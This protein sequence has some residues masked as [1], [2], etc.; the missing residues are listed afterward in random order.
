MIIVLA[1]PLPASAETSEKPRLNYYRKTLCVKKTYNLNRSFKLKVIGT[2]SNVRFLTSNKKIAAVNTSG[3]VIAKK[4]GKVTITAT[5][6]G[7]KLKCHVTVKPLSK[8]SKLVRNNTIK[9]RYKIKKKRIL[10]IN[11]GQLSKYHNYL[12]MTDIGNYYY[13]TDNIFKLFLKDK[14]T[15][16]QKNKY[17]GIVEKYVRYK[18]SK[19]SVCKVNKKGKIIPKKAGSAIV[20]VRLI[21][22]TFKI[23]VNVTKKQFLTYKGQKSLAVYSDR[24]VYNALKDAFYNHI[25]KGEKPKYKYLT[26]FYKVKSGNC[27][28]KDTLEN[29]LRKYA[30]SEMNSGNNFYAYITRGFFTGVFFYISQDDDSAINEELSNSVITVGLDPDILE[31]VNLTYTEA[32]EIF[33]NY[34]VDNCLT[35]Y[36]KLKAIDLWSYDNTSYGPAFSDIDEYSIL[37]DH[38]GICTTYS[39][40]M[41]YLCTLLQIPCDLAMSDDH[42]WNVCQVDGK[43]YYF[44]VLHNVLLRGNNGMIDDEMY[45]PRDIAN[46]EGKIQIEDENYEFN[47]IVETTEPVTSSE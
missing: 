40:G 25:I 42:M 36:E 30:L 13:E 46:L 5:V 37:V 17:M 45:Q 39:F 21:N 18:S 44:D 27:L 43:W 12:D 31:Y 38:V 11:I 20:T 32:Q 9:I 41:L 7:R 26:C 16:R 23:K 22:K 28:N 34:G 35:D 19:P 15:N 47:E 6:N 10:S 14:L 8:F 3:K 4:S 29:H 24:D 2:E 33:R 1:S